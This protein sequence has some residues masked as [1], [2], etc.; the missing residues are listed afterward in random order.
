M[1]VYFISYNKQSKERWLLIV[2][3]KYDI[4]KD[5]NPLYVCVLSGHWTHPHLSWPYFQKTVVG[6]LGITFSFS[7]LLACLFSFNQGSVE[8][9]IA[10]T[11]FYLSCI[12]FLKVKEKLLEKLNYQLHSISHY[13][14]M[15]PC[16]HTS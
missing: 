13:P 15:C 1:C 16:V 10:R 4:T 3:Q 7:F 12:V 14:E 2:I 6:A 8:F 5:P 11:R 9:V